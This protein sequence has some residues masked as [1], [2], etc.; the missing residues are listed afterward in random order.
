MEFYDVH[1]SYID[2]ETLEEHFVMVEEQGGG[3]LIPEGSGKPGLI[4]AIGLSRKG[5][6]GLYRI[7]LQVTKR[8]GR[9]ATSGLWNFSSAAQ[10]ASQDRFRP[11]QGERSAHQ[12][13]C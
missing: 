6:P 11:L 9:L 1:F 2:N 8:S 13:K 3:G 4:H 7:V 5:M 10:G 12:P